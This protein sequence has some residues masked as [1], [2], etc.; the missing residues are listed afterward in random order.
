MIAREQPEERR[1]DGVCPRDS[2]RDLQQPGLS[3]TSAIVRSAA[4]LA[5][6]SAH[7]ARRAI[8]R[9]LGRYAPRTRPARTTSVEWIELGPG[10]H[11]A[12]RDARTIGILY[13]KPADIGEVPGTVTEPVVLDPGFFYMPVGTPRDHH[14][15]LTG[16][17]SP[18]NWRLALRHASALTALEA[19]D[20][21]DL[22]SSGPVLV[23]QTCRHVQ[24]HP[25]RL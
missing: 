22:Q 9:V 23:A 10:S 21:R 24:T 4:P 19:E 16:P 1:A 11:C 3:L 18:A 15:V 2:R 25:P 12:L 6:L 20:L 5:S 8:P 14:L 7:L 17:A 13:W